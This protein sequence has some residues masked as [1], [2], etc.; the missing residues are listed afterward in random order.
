VLTRGLIAAVLEVGLAVLA[1]PAAVM[2]DELAGIEGIYDRPADL[3]RSH[4]PLLCLLDTEHPEVVLADLKKKGADQYKNRLFRKDLERLA[5]VRCLLLHYTQVTRK[6]L[7][8]P[9]IKALV[10]TARKK[11]IN[12]QYDTELFAII[13]AIQIPTIGLC[14]GHQL[15]AQTYGGKYVLMRKLKPGEPDPR[16]QYWPG[17]FKE[18]GFMNVNIVRSDPLFAGFRNTLLIREFHAYEV[19]QLPAE[20]DVLASTEECRVQVIR[21]KEKPLYGTQFHPERYDKEHPD[22]EVV[23]KN[24]LRLADLPPAQ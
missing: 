13:R 16:P 12:R 9:K 6:D 19:T 2:A 1:V 11:R 3:N 18:W 8:N 17:H 14:G 22:G 20:F 21:H 23:L 24:F 15:I 5:R 10:I 7:A 4:G